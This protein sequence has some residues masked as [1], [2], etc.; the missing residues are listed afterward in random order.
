MVAAIYAIGPKGEFGA[1]TASGLPWPTCKTDLARFKAVTSCY[2]NIIVGRTTYNKIGSL[3]GRKMII[4]SKN[5]HSLGLLSKND[6]NTQWM[7][8][9]EAIKLNNSIVI[10]G[11][12]LLEAS[13]PFLHKIMR[14]VI[15]YPKEDRQFDCSGITYCTPDLSDF[16]KSHT[17]LHPDHEFQIFN[18]K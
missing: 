18:R 3:K 8:F 16:Y 1:N 7:S 12:A 13:L 11:T 9:E 4:V 17:E 15:Y 2:D 6:L 14:S 10:G 5:A